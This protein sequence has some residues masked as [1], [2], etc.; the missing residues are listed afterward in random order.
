MAASC[1]GGAL[2]MRALL[3]DAVRGPVGQAVAAAARGAASS[4]GAQRAAYEP[5][6]KLDSVLYML[7]AAS[8]QQAVACL[9]SA[10]RG[11]VAARLQKLSKRRNALAH[12]D[13]G[14]VPEIA[15]MVADGVYVGA[16]VQH[17][18]GSG[19]EQ[20]SDL[21][22]GPAEFYVGEAVAEVAVQTIELEKIAYPT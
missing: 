15:A 11:D 17:E 16:D 21:R 5:A 18:D 1:A 3:R 9:R 4:A 2:A 22:D 12:G 13:V 7:G 19:G 10:D 6:A 20:E 14:L 8:V